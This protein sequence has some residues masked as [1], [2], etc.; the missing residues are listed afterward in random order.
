MNKEDVFNY[1][2]LIPKGMVTTYKDIANYYKS[3]G[4]QAVGK[5]LHSNTDKL[6]NPCYKVVSKNGALSSN[7]KFGGKEEQFKLLQNDDIPFNE[8]RVCLDKCEFK[9]IL[10]TER[11]YLRELVENDLPALEKMMNDKV[12]FHY[13][14]HFTKADVIDWYNK[15]RERYKA[16]FG[17]LACCLKENCTLI[18]QIGFTVQEIPNAKVIELGYIFGDNYWHN[19]YCIEASK[20]LIDYA[21]SHNY[22]EIYSIIKYNNYQSQKVALKNNMTKVGE[23]VKIYL[24]KPML[25][26]IY[27]VKL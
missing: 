26:Y 2:K 7:Y 18:G 20:V 14:H 13:E 24:G 15:Q 25:H 5:I 6:I 10:E 9:L 22:K 21:K 4:Y 3:K 17:L 11:L 19:G 1:I 23:F 27:K 16:N 8:D 12:M